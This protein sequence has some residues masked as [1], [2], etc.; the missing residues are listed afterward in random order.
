MSDTYT[1]LN[2]IKEK[3]E[4]DQ[5][6]ALNRIVLNMLESKRKEDFWLRI[7]L[8]ISILTNIVISCIFIGYESQFTTEKTITTTVTQ[9]TGEGE[10]NN[11]YQ[12]GEHANYVQGNTEEVTPYG[13]TNDQNNYNNYKNKDS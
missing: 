5:S 10:G 8:I 4:L 3:E 6:V 7:V 9:D 1:D 12:S 2:E 13:E 11:V